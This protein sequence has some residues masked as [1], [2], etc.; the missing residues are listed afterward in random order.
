MAKVNVE[1]VATEIANEI[2]SGRRF[3]HGLVNGYVGDCFYSDINIYCDNK[4][5][6]RHSQKSDVYSKICSILRVNKFK[7]WS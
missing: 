6:K 2:M 5:G 3:Q 1:E 7:I 4:L